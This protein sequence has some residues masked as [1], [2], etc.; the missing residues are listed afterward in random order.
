MTTAAAITI[1]HFPIIFTQRNRFFPLSIRFCCY[2]LFNA[3]RKCTNNIVFS[4]TNNHENC[5]NQIYQGK[6]GM[7]SVQWSVFVLDFS[8]PGQIFQS[9]NITVP[10]IIQSCFDVSIR[11]FQ[12]FTFR[13]Y[14]S[15]IPTLIL[16]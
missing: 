8:V 5:F 15:K 9:K 10:Y 3:H 13:S 16:T 14:L 7:T 6:L 12:Y 2:H 11:L 1:V 4:K